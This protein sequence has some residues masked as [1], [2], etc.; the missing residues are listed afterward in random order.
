MNFEF[1]PATCSNTHF[2]ALEAE[3]RD[4]LRRIAD[5]GDDYESPYI[6]HARKISSEKPTDSRYGIY[7]L[8]DTGAAN[9][10]GYKGMVHINHAW[11]GT[12]HATLRMLWMILAPEYDFRD[13]NPLEIGELAAG[14]LYGGIDLCHTT[15]RSAS[16]KMHLG[17]LVAR[18]YV[19]ALVISLRRDEPGMQVAIR[20]NWLH[21][22]NLKSG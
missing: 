11:P 18:E 17:N 19:S 15:K 20:G 7:V 8:K 3:W 5:A 21:V 2:S 13:L 6:E 4:Q 9:G 22:D 16:L 14:F 1:L 12:S 10:S